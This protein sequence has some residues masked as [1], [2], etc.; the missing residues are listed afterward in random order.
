MEKN[1]MRKLT[2]STIA[3]ASILATA[4]TAGAQDFTKISL[5]NPTTKNLLS[6]LSPKKDWSE[7]PKQ[8]AWICQ[9]GIFS[10]FVM[11]GYIGA[12]CYCFTIW[13]PAYG[14]IIS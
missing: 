11:N 3:I 12:P 13:G 10:C 6:T 7:R 8:T 4:A 9:A 2:I 1:T 14:W 5:G